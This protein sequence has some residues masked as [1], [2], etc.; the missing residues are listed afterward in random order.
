MHDQSSESIVEMPHRNRPN[1]RP[2]RSWLMAFTCD[3]F[4]LRYF[5]GQM[6]QLFGPAAFIL[7]LT[8]PTAMASINAHSTHNTIQSCKLH[9]THIM[10][11]DSM[12]LCVCIHSAIVFIHELLYIFWRRYCGPLLLFC[13][14]FIH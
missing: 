8:I 10:S 14:K 11:V 3:S 13:S 6:Y 4:F 7:A 1:E 5:F 12:S 9:Q 2:N